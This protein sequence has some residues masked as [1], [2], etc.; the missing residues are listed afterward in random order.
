MENRGFEEKVA[1]YISENRLFNIGSRV[2]VTVSGGADSVA[3]LCLLNGL[4]YDCVAAHCNF[5]RCA[6]SWAWNA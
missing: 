2:L 6:A 5:V 4:G 1:V 3:L